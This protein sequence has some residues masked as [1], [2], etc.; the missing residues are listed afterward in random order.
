MLRYFIILVNAALLALLLMGIPEATHDQLV[1]YQIGRGPT[2]RWLV[3]WGLAGAAA[4]NLLATLVLI[5]DQKV[6][7]VGWEWTGIFAA[8]GLFQYALI[9]AWVN[10]DWL[11]TALEWCQKHL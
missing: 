1:G 4:L 9:R 10:F 2:T 7:A 6:R 5:K 3:M 11:K 8:L